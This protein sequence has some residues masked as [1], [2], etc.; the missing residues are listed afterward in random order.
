VDTP[1]Q[2]TT[3]FRFFDVASGLQVGYIWEQRCGNPGRLYFD[4]TVSDDHPIPAGGR[5]VQRPR[6]R[7]ATR[8]R[9]VAR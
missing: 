8:A 2:V 7:S 5:R 1:P 3:P 4:V 9:V 6:S